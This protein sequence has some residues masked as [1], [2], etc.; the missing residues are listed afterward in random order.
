MP[1]EDFAGAYTAPAFGDIVFRVE[2]DE[3]VADLPLHQVRFSHWHDNVFLWDF[4][5][6]D[7]QMLVEFRIGFDNSVTALEWG[8]DSFTK[9]D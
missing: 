9:I 5:Q 8:S 3:L 2:G 6:W 4:E 7:F 1:L